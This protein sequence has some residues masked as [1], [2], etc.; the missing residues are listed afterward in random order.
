[1]SLEEGLALQYYICL[2]YGD[3]FPVLASELIHDGQESNA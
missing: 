3:I 2:L 1:M